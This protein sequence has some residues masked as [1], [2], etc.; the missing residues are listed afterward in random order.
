MHEHTHHGLGDGEQHNGKQQP[1]ARKGRMR[2][3]Y[4]EGDDLVGLPFYGS[5]GIKYSPQNNMYVLKWKTELLWS[6]QEP[7]TAAERDEITRK[8]QQLNRGGAMPPPKARAASGGAHAPTRKRTAPTLVRQERRGEQPEEQAKVRS[9]IAIAIDEMQSP[10]GP[11]WLIENLLPLRGLAVV[12]GPPKSGK[13]Y[14]TQ[15]LLGSVARGVPYGGRAV[16]GGPV[17]YLTGEGVNGF[18]RR[19]IAM[20]EHLQI[21]GQGVPFF[22]IKKVPDLGSEETDLG[23]LLD[24]LD[25]FIKDRNLPPPRAIVLDTLARC[26]REGATKTPAGT[27]GA[28]LT[29]V[30]RS[31]GISDAWLLSS[32]TWARS[33]P[34]A[35]AAPMH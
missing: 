20:R 30:E 13:S 8:V 2:C 7:P 35:A 12:V 34:P 25:Q 18:E 9:F 16:V 19:V 6:G 14:F 31:S 1:A 5:P 15:Y 22:T 24:D 17:I 26:M 11:E 21:T 27:W 3:I 4:F 32:T 10:I 28:S 33:S 29:D 23:V